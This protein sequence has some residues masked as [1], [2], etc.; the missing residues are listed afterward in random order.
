MENMQ[1]C[2][3]ELQAGAEGL[4]KAVAA[5]SSQLKQQLH[6][7]TAIANGGTTQSASPISA[8]SSPPAAIQE[9]PSALCP[10]A[11]ALVSACSAMTSAAVADA[12]AAATAAI[13]PP[14]SD[15]RAVATGQKADVKDVAESAELPQ[16]QESSRRRSHS[17]LPRTSELAAV[18]ASREAGSRGHGSP[19][20]RAARVSSSPLVSRIS[21]APGLGQKPLE[22]LSSLVTSPFK[23]ILRAEDGAS[24]QCRQSPSPC[25]PVLQTPA[26]ASCSPGPTARIQGPLRSSGLRQRP[27]SQAV[28][29][30]AA[31]GASSSSCCNLS[32]SL[33]T[34]PAHPVS[35]MSM[36]NDRCARCPM[37]RRIQ[38]PC[39]GGSSGAPAMPVAL[40]PVAGPSGTVMSHPAAS[41]DA[42]AA[43]TKLSR[44]LTP[45]RANSP[46]RM[47]S[48]QVLSPLRR[49]AMSVKAAPAGASATP[50]VSSSSI[51]SS[52]RSVTPI[53]SSHQQISAVS[54]HQQ[55]SA[56]RR[57]GGEALQSMVSDQSQATQPPQPAQRSRSTEE[58]EL[59][60]TF[61]VDEQD[62]HARAWPPKPPA[63]SPQNLQHEEYTE[64]VKRA[65]QMVHS[66][67][68]EREESSRCAERDEP[69][70]RS[71]S[72]TRRLPWSSPQ[73]Q[74]SSSG[75]AILPPPR[76]AGTAAAGTSGLRLHASPMSVS[77]CRSASPLAAQRVPTSS[78]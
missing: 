54:S 6:S 49:T 14:V 34:L 28:L 63:E 24:V 53:L 74:L 3:A 73:C 17:T 43:V 27:P 57:F 33:S 61:G 69:T 48:A 26:S 36:Q 56:V 75:L 4:T 52:T 72:P 16:L 25:A 20:S 9:S 40:M 46:V 38:L 11:A 10:E 76:P 18:A 12:D 35:M 64:R 66:K 50:A 62:I 59:L 21:S 32:A 78:P 37:C 15:E 67:R 13:V 44:T 30:T 31:A 65:Q 47:R 70:E 19:T 42:P 23:R 77:T 71:P 60:P 58:S 7:V 68:T 5:T 22:R 1:S 41:S 2:L 8:S 29:L 55:I 51:S 45:T 39:P